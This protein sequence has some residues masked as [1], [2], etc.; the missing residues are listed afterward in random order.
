M[1]ST[2]SSP[3]AQA[4]S[5]TESLAAR[6][7][8]LFALPSART[9]GV[10]LVA[11]S[12]LVS[13]AAERGAVAPWFVAGSLLAALFGPLAV[14]R[15]CRAL[16]KDTVAN[17]RRAAATIFAGEV[18]WLVCVGVGLAASLATGS[19][20]PV[21]NATVFGAFAAAGFEFLVINGVFLGSA[22]AS[23]LLCAVHPALTLAFLAAF[24]SPGRLDPYA[25]LAGALA[26]GVC[27]S[28]L[29]ALGRRATPGGYRSLDF[30]RAFM[31]TWADERPEALER[32]IGAHATKA[33]VSTKVMRFGQ[34]GRDLFV[35]LPGVHP[36]PFFPIGSYNLPGLLYRSF[37]GLGPELTLHRPGGHERN[38]ATKEDTE[39]FAAAIVGLAASISRQGPPA[40]VRGPVKSVVGGASCAAMA[41]GEDLLLT[42]SFAPLGS[43]D[44]ELGLESSLCALASADGLDL[45][46]VDAHNSIE[47][48]RGVVDPADPGWRELF[49]AVG[50]APVSPFR[51]GYA[52]SDEVGMHHGSDVAE[53]GI[54]LVVFETGGRKHALILADANNAVP[55]L[56]QEVGEA[57]ESAGV[58][59][60]ELCTSDSHDRAARGVTVGRGYLALGEATQPRELVDG[61][62]KLAELAGT[63]LAPA[64]Y[65]SRSLS[66]AVNVYGAGA[67]EDFAKLTESSTAFARRY[68]AFIIVSALALLAISILA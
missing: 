26:L 47:P 4:K 66:S 38:L 42:V 51:L 19:S 67:L 32:M 1:S 43:E 20:R 21:E 17:F 35:V 31:K 52:H 28:F 62:V 36:G 41:F 65:A 15:C 44:I 30:F 45:S 50:S 29:L 9:L 55:A 59:L 58:S 11:S 24:A 16:E 27:V 34:E 18:V 5:P 25:V 54:G 6:Y 46:V 22:P 64:T 48:E 13:V 2:R 12:L 63:R 49:R 61:I 3:E 7:R 37:K 60:L 68:S 23:S 33:E 56:R 10:L 39:A 57:L 40:E 53:A 8:H 14:S